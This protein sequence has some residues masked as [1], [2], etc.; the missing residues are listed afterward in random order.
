MPDEMVKFNSTEYQRFMKLLALTKPSTAAE[1]LAAVE[2]LARRAGVDGLRLS[3][4]PAA[5]ETNP[6]TADAEKRAAE[7]AKAAGA[8]G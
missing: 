5:D 7:A 2:D 3:F 6:L 4:G 8:G 1:V